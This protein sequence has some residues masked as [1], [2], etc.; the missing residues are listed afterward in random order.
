MEGILWQGG[1]SKFTTVW[2]A[3]TKERRFANVQAS[4]LIGY[5]VQASMA[6]GS[7]IAHRRLNTYILSGLIKFLAKTR[8]PLQS[9]RQVPTYSLG[10]D[11]NDGFSLCQIEGKPEAK[12]VTTVAISATG[13]SLGVNA[14][15]V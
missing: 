12:P 14:L 7:M 15:T 3:M 9:N 11:N 13:L 1:N 8:N 5:Q 10:L 4:L 6:C 2:L